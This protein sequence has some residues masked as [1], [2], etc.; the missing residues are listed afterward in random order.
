[1]WLAARE[2]AELAVSERGSVSLDQVALLSSSLLRQC[3]GSVPL[4]CPPSAP[5][6][7]LRILTLPSYSTGLVRARKSPR[8]SLLLR[9]LA[10][11]APVAVA[12]GGD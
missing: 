10:P 9:V 5:Q 12:Q 7:S 6:F 3:Q 2:V 1:M 4:L 8:L 11:G